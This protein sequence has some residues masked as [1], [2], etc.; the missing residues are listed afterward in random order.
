[1]CDSSE[2]IGIKN[3]LSG[4]C[5]HCYGVSANKDF[6]YKIDFYYIYRS[7]LEP[8]YIFIQELRE[9]HFYEELFIF[10]NFLSEIYDHLDPFITFKTFIFQ[11]RSLLEQ[12]NF[13]TISTTEYNEA[14]SIY[15]SPL[16]FI[17]KHPVEIIKD[18]N[19][20][21]IC[22]FFL[23][24]EDDF[25]IEKGV[26]YLYLMLNSETGYYKIGRSCNPQYRER[27][28][29][30]RE[31][32]IKLLHAWKCEKNIEKLIHRKFHKKRIRGEWFKLSL[33]DLSGFNKMVCEM[34]EAG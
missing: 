11:H 22:K 2:T 26:N 9:K 17:T 34:I 5:E 7:E 16:E 6:D 3:V 25:V 13:I 21:E 27:T 18:F 24:I 14:K 8:G 23:K 31:A 1:M 19:R 29:Q 4:L 12:F 10:C 32:E 33:K 20:V 30:S 28:L 15:G